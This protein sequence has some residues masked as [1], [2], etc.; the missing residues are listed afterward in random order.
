[1][2]SG[3]GELDWDR[4]G[5]DWPN[6]S[7]SRF[8][9]AGRVR[10]HVQVIG[11]GPACLMLHGT[12]A[13]THTWRDLVPVLRQHF[14]LII[15]DLPGHGF[16][17]MPAQELVTLPGYASLLASLLSKLQMQPALMIGHSAGAAIAAEMVLQADASPL[18]IIS[19]NGA[20]VP[21]GG[22][23]DRFFSPLAKLLSL[24]PLMPRMFAWRATSP[25]TVRRLLEGTGSHCGDEGLEWYRRLLSSPA[26]CSAALQMMARWDLE[27]MPERI[28]DLRCRLLLVRGENDKAIPERDTQLIHDSVPG[29]QLS[30][31]RGVGHLAHEENPE[32][33][34]E[35]ILAA[36]RDWRQSCPAAADSGQ[37]EAATC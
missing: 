9:L 18:G 15:P 2:L 3:L 28:R 7:C 16:S 33:A 26:H 29:A 6:R 14:T 4:D 32:Q 11:D 22:V 25:G 8:V 24:N 30:I 12:G 31:M 5:A 21:M 19:F 36:W 1:M 35:I 13:S 27:T 34:V 17:S 37:R 20:F 10:F 23:G